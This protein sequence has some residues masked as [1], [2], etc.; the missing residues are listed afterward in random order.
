MSEIQDQQDEHEHRADK[1]WPL[2]AIALALIVLAGFLISTLIHR[3]VTDSRPS[4]ERERDRWVRGCAGYGRGLYYFLGLGDLC[5]C[6][7]ESQRLGISRS[8]ICS[9]GV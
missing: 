1:N 9:R 7:L 8:S 6:W 3:N 5:T 4:K 2:T